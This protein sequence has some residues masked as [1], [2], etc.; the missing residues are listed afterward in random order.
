MGSGMREAAGGEG[1]GTEEGLKFGIRVPK[2]GMHI[3]Q[4]KKIIRT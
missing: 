3:A 4:R 1:K 2:K